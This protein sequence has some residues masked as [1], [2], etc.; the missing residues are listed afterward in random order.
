MIPQLTDRAFKLLAAAPVPGAV[1]EFGVYQGGGLIA[2]AH[3]A[4]KYLGRVPDLYGFDTFQGIPASDVNLTG[5]TAEDW[6]PA[7]FGDTSL[8]Q[9]E[10]RLADEGVKATL[11]ANMF[12]DVGSLSEHGIESVMLAHIDADLYE[13]YRDALALLTPHLRVGSIVLCDESVPPTDSSMQSVRDHGQRA[14][15]EWEEASGFN[16]H[17]IRFEWTIG[18][19][20]IVDDAYLDAHWRTIDDLRKDTP[21]ESL[22]NIAKKVLGRPREAR[23]FLP[24]GPSNSS[25]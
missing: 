14:L 6:A 15:R 25:S 12:S 1:T 5:K 3:S 11:V 8:E 20:V 22:K 7:M 23:G 17:L 9:V 10:K 13:G 24:P 21:V 2:M 19:Y 16:L 4:Q 18:L